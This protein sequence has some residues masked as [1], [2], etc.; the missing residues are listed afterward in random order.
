MAILAA[1]TLCKRYQ[2]GHRSVVALDDVS[3]EVGA[4]EIVVV[5]GRSGAGKSTL[6]KCLLGLERPDSGTVLLDG[7]PLSTLDATAEQRYR[8]T[9][10]PVMQDPGSSLPPR[11]RIG[12]L[13]A[14][15]LRIHR[16]ASGAEIESRVVQALAE[17]ELG[18]ELLSR[19]PH[20]LSGGQLQR[21]AIARALIGEPRVLLADEPTSA[22]DVVTGM[23]VA[24]LL[25]SLVE[26]H[27]L[28]LVV[29]THDAKLAHHLGAR[30]MHM[31]AGRVTE[32]T[33][34]AQWL[35]QVRARW[36][37]ARS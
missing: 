20:E 4:G 31:D 9:V 24:L 1:Q 18:P 2:D 23:H 29:V 16:L 34:S 14:E 5:A 3:L 36:E 13:V 28:G 21:I 22:L 8:R 7:E 30:V 27:G 11:M 19:F 15:P 37:Q 12:R 17:V 26:K 33:S 10:Q 25:R 6:L 32:T 35:G